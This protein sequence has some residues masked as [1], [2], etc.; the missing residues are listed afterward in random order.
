VICAGLKSPTVPWP[1]IIDGACLLSILAAATIIIFRT[2]PTR[3]SAIGYLVFSGGF[4]FYQYARSPLSLPYYA[5][6]YSMPATDSTSLAALLFFLLHDDQV[7]SAFPGGGVGISPNYLTFLDIYH[8]A[9]ATLLGLLGSLLAQ[10][11]YAT[12]PRESP[13]TT[14]PQP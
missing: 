9:L 10:Y 2:G 12:Q 14:N 5:L 11:L 3:A 13:A 7:G 1:T 4:F 6:S 8:H